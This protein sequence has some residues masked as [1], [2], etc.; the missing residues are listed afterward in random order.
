M[1]ECAP[2]FSHPLVDAYGADPAD[3]I[4]ALVRSQ[5]SDILQRVGRQP[6][7]SKPNAESLV[8]TST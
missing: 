2:A 8:R 7:S 6:V 4:V 5:R 3:R 1:K